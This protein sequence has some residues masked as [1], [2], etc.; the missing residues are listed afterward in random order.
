VGNQAKSTDAKATQAKAK[1]TKPLFSH[2]EEAFVAATEKYFEMVSRVLTIKESLKLAYVD[3]RMSH[4][5]FE[6]WKRDANIAF[7]Q[8]VVM[9]RRCL[10][11]NKD[12]LAK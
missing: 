4:V 8:L 9:R 2:S 10:K 3:Q 1:E 5:Y 12:P 11:A 6:D 7:R